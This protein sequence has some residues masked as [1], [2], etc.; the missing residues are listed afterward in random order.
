MFLDSYN[1]CYFFHHTNEKP[2]SGFDIHATYNQAV[3]TKPKGIWFCFGNKNGKHDTLEEYCM[4]HHG[5][6]TQFASIINKI[7][8]G[9][10][11]PFYKRM[12]YVQNSY[13]IFNIEKSYGV[14]VNDKVHLNWP[15]IA[16]KYSGIILFEQEPGC[17]VNYGFQKDKTGSNN[18]WLE[19]W[20]LYSGC[21][22]EPKYLKIIKEWDL[23]A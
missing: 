4:Q 14:I 20:S 17:L 18:N 1:D 15:K 8:I 6:N 16:R 2:F 13:D 22:W 23:N 10:D 5:L 9:I 3:G 7:Q 11:L 19:T 21:I 12:L